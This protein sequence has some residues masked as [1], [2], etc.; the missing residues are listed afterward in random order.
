MAHDGRRHGPDEVSRELQ[1]GA[2]RSLASPREL[3]GS[4]W[5]KMLRERGLRKIRRG[6]RDDDV[7]EPNGG[8]QALC[9]TGY[10]REECE[11]GEGA[12]KGDA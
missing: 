4:T 11:D 10:G 1:K 8:G 3:F 7:F 6:D 12:R 5:R 2:Q 9:P